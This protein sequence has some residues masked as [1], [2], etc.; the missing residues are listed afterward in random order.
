MRLNVNK[1]LEIKIEIVKHIVSNK[2]EE[3]ENIKK[4]KEIASEKDK[5]AR[6]IEDKKNEALKNMTIEELENRL[7]NLK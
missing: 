7:D 2:L 4:K 3:I 6:T 1:D 5:I